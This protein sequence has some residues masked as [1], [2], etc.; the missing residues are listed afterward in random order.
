MKVIGFNKPT[1][2]NGYLSIYYQAPFYQD[3]FSKSIEEVYEI[4]TH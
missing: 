2:D 1:G 3:G 4:L